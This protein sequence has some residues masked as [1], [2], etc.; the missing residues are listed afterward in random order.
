MDGV[1]QIVSRWAVARPELDVSALKVFGRL[2][3]SFLVYK[4]RI[5]AT[6]EEHNITDSGFD[7]LACLRRA[8][9]DHRLTAGELAELTLVTTGGLSLRVKRLEEAG[10]VTRTRDSDDARVVYVTL[11]PSGAELVDRV[12]DEH[13]AKLTSMLDEL[14]DRDAAQ[15]ARLLGRLEK[16][17]RSAHLGDGLDP[18]E[19]DPI[20]AG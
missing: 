8:V 1:D 10:L 13:F 12:A 7:V 2:H 5:A 20:T 6:F 14:S 17:A 9:P 18:G 15:L 16:S 3:R 19:S 11:T 4:A